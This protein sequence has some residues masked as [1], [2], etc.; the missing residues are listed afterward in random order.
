MHC[1]ACH[2][3]D[4]PKNKCLLIIRYMCPSELLGGNHKTKYQVTSIEKALSFQLEDVTV[5]F[6][7]R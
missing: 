1:S 7:A 5:K 6:C 4:I 2:T 3:N